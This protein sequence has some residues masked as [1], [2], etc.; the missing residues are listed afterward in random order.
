MNRRGFRWLGALAFAGMLL[1][2]GSA[3][4]QQMAGAQSAVAAKRVERGKY[5]VR[6]MVCNDCHT[7]FKMG[8]NGPEPDMSRMLSGHPEGMKL[9]PPPKPAGP[10]IEIGVPNSAWAGP[11]GISYSANLTPDKTTGPGIW[12]EDMFL[13]AMKTGKHMGTSREIQPPMPW[14]SYGQA[15]DEDLKAIFAYLKSIPPIVNHV[16]D[17]APPSGAPPTPAAKGVAPKKK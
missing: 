10:W 17:Y 12:T 15:T 8:P 7:P 14:Q 1:P 4:A 11:W 16:P 6:I 3:I 5:L 13:K 9:P 2:V